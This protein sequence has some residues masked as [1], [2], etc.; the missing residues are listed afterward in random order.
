[1]AHPIDLEIYFGNGLSA[2]WFN[3]SVL[4][5]ISVDKFCKLYGTKEELKKPNVFSQSN[6]NRRYNP[7]RN[8]Q[9]R[10]KSNNYSHC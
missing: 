7:A 8:K 9:V 10:I 6:P 5:Y 3:E 1:M 2:G 4:K